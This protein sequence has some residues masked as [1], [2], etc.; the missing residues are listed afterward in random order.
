MP[1]GNAY[2]VSSPAST[3]P[4]IRQT[5]T[6]FAWCPDGTSGAIASLP[7]VEVSHDGQFVLCSVRSLERHVGSLRA[8]MP[9]HMPRF[10]IG[11]GGS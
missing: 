10:R 6:E 5:I 4:V 11:S 8:A 2:A 1:F 7:N 3:L 9:A